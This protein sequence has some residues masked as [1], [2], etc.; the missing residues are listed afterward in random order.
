MPNKDIFDRKEGWGHT[1]GTEAAGKDTLAAN[2]TTA[3]WEA[4]TFTV[5][6]AATEA[7]AT[8]IAR[9]RTARQNIQ[10]DLNADGAWDGTFT[11]TGSNTALADSAGNA[12]RDVKGSHASSA[13][14]D[15]TARANTGFADRTTGWG[16]GPSASV[17][18]D[19]EDA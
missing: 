13:S 18:N 6:A 9:T 5:P 19:L 4:D 7:L 15:A 2:S 16:H 11:T 10:A 8:R 1:A 14:M 12:N 17:A 3:Q